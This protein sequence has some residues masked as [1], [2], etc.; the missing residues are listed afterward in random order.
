MKTISEEWKE[1]KSIKEM[2][3]KYLRDVISDDAG[4]N[5]ITESKKVF[6]AGCVT[7]FRLVLDA[8]EADDEE[9]A[10]NYFDAYRDE[11]ED[12]IKKQIDL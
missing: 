8:A 7:M 5:Q 6:Y 11:L 1:M 2:W 4:I 12:N 3:E 9:E 10:C